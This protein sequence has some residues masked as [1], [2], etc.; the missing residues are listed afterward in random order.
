M[1]EELKV[2]D[3]ILSSVKKLIGVP[4]ESE[5]FDIDIIFH[6]NAAFA[7]LFQLGVIDKAYTIT[8]KENKYSEIISNSMPDILSNIRIYL[9]YK[10]K[11]GFDSSTLSTNVI[12][13]LEKMIAELEYRLMI[14]SNFNND[15]QTEGEV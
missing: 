1:E 10:T 11:I 4:V 15:T 13:T 8:S 7:T 14:S 12:T 5:S 6:I 3:S 2:S 9:V